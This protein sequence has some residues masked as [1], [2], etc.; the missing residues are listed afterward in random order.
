[1]TTVAFYED[2]KINKMMKNNLQQI[3][4]HN[5]RP[6]VIMAQLANML[7]PKYT[8][9]LEDTEIIIKPDKRKNLDQVEQEIIKLTETLLHGMDINFIF[10]L[11]KSSSEI[12]LKQKR[13]Q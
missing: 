9:L 12:I 11:S 2:K 1:M 7:K 13:T 3:Q 6:K 10:R 4:Q 5:I 8:V